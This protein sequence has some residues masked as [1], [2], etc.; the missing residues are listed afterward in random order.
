MGS[1]RSRAPGIIP[2]IMEGKKKS[3]KI[4]MRE[5]DRLMS[6]IFIK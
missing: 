1:S 5:N 3:E 4:E 2:D 6:V